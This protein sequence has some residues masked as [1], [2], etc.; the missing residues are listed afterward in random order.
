MLEIGSSLREARR[1][2]QLGLADVEAATRIRTQQLEA[3]ERERFE[4]LPP[5]PYRRSFLRETAISSGSMA[6]S[7]CTS[8]TFASELRSRH[9]LPRRRADAW[10]LG[11]YLARA[12][13]SWLAA[14]SRRSSVSPSGFSAAP[15]AQPRPRRSRQHTRGQGRRLTP[16]GMPHPNERLVWP[17]ERLFS[18]VFVAAAGFGCGS[19]P[20]AGP[21]ST[22]RRCKR[23][24]RFG[25]GCVGRS[26]SGSARLGTN[27]DAAIGRRSL[28]H[29]LPV[30]TGDV[31]V[32]T[33]GLR[34][35]A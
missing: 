28:S 15:V 27:I 23:G 4:L 1:R 11:V 9:H 25:S 31:L 7:T 33:A 29:A 12:R 14:W 13:C 30:R 24:R 3:L 32:T 6:T 19:A 8:T 26:G 34:A 16:T 10:S 22:S 18:P 21:R 35:A 17:R 5:D 20:P 2:R